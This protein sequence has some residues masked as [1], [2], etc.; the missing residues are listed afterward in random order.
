MAVGGGVGQ[1]LVHSGGGWSA[2]DSVVGGRWSMGVWRDAV[3]LLD[4]VGRKP[5]GY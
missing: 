2:Q 5:I 3:V 4:K 1:T